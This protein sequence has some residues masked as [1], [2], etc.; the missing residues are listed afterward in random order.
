ME[1]MLCPHVMAGSVSPQS[2]NAKSPLSA[3]RPQIVNHAKVLE[4]SWEFLSP[5]NSFLLTCLDR[6]DDRTARFVEVPS[7]LVLPN[8]AYHGQILRLNRA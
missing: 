6:V 5:A 7:L 1:E 4:S 8:H 3:S 2:R